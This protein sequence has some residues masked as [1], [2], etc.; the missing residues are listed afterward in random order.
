MGA[1]IRGPPPNEG[2]KTW[3]EVRGESCAGAPEGHHAAEILCCG[4]VGIGEDGSRHPCTR[5]HAERADTPVC[6]AGC[7]AGK[8]PWLKELPPPHVVPCVLHHVMGVNRLLCSF[9]VASVAPENETKVKR[10]LYIAKR[11]LD[12]PNALHVVTLRVEA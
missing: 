11:G 8:Q 12:A 1:R 4:G 2:P 5:C 9:L 7:S 6:A 3:E 10:V